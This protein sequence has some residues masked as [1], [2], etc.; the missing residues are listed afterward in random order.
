MCNLCTYVLSDLVH[1]RTFIRFP[2]LLSECII[3]CFWRTGKGP[4]PNKRLESSTLTYSLFLSELHYV[5]RWT[6]SLK[7]NVEQKVCCQCLTTRGCANKT[8]HSSEI[9]ICLLKHLHATISAWSFDIKLNVTNIVSNFMNRF[10]FKRMLGTW[11]VNSKH[12]FNCLFSWRC[13]IIPTSIFQ[14]KAEFKNRC[15]LQQAKQYKLKTLQEHLHFQ[16]SF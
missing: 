4:K 8:P 1:L 10:F 2:V 11:E 13:F 15:F 6:C 14:K 7:K 16:N 9:Y 5:N 12:K 3:S